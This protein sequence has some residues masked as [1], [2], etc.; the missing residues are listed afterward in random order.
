MAVITMQN[1]KEHPDFP[2]R[3]FGVYF[4]KPDEYP[5]DKHYHDCDEAWLVL[6][7]KARVLSEGKEYVVSAGDV[8]WTRMGDEHQLLEII[9]PTYGVAWMENALRGRKRP[10]HLYKEGSAP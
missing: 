9:E 7:G 4:F 8:V 1:V 3:Q 5:S 10:G 2:F 6:S